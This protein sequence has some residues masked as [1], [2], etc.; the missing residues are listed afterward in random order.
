MTNCSAKKSIGANELK[1]EIESALNATWVQRGR[2][3][4]PDGRFPWSQS[5]AQCPSSIEIDGNI[6]VYYATRDADN[7]SRTSFVDLARND[8]TRILHV[9]D[10]PVMD[11]GEP[12]THDEDGVMVSCV[13]REGDEL[14]MYYSG[15]S[16]SVQ[17]PY[18]VSVG[19]AISRDGGL[20]FERCFKGPV[21]DRT[22]DEPY[23]T[24]APCVLRTGSFWTM[25]YGSGIR[26]I[27]IAGKFEPIYVIKM[28]VSPDGLRWK[29]HN[30]TCIHQ[31]H[32]LEANTRPSVLANDTGYDMW[33]SYRHSRSFRDGEG[34]YRMGHA[35]SPDGSTWMR[36]GSPKGL[37]PPGVGWNSV[38][39]AYPNVI[40]VAG[41]KIMFHNGNGFGRTGFGFA[42]C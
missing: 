28:A 16:R 42:T 7:R 24:M 13:V 31:S 4:V 22:S 14:R 20:S 29:Q 25:W 3:F 33:F 9:F 2:L 8:P 32:S 30:Q 38:T 12:G 15:W 11:L 23:M 40:V 35:T 17:V 27:S 34:S 6:R 5:H 21:V 18:R 26:W 10:R 37:D 36:E 41:Q 39:M 1:P 19:L